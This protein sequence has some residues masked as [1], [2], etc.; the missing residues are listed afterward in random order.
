VGGERKEIELKN[1][2]EELGR[3]G[4]W[5]AELAE[6]ESIDPKTLFQLNLVCDELV[7][8]TILYGC[9]P[10]TAHTIWISLIMDPKAIEVTITDDGLAFDPLSRPSPD[11]TLPLDERKIGGLGIHFV[12]EAMDEAVYERVGSLNTIRMTKTGWKTPLEE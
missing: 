12:R 4:I 5:L 10:D 2:L 3:L 6:Q 8:N 7:T 11:V 1:D 9:N